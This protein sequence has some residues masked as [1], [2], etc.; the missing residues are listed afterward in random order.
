MQFRN[1]DAV[2]GDIFGMLIGIAN[3]NLQSSNGQ[4]LYYLQLY[5]NIRSAKYILKPK[6]CEEEEFG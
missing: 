2:H 5:I 4:I 6:D 3:G 1:F